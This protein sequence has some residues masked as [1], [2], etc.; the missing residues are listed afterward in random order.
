MAAKVKRCA[1]CDRRLRGAADDWCAELGNFD[2]DG[3][4]EVTAIICPSCA[5]VEEH[6][7]R[8]ISDAMT[9]YEWLGDRVARFPKFPKYPVLN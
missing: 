4:G 7:A 2:P 6:L 5:T 1:R 8:E 9:D 3:Y